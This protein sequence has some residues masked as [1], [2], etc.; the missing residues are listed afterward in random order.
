[1]VETEVIETKTTAHVVSLRK[2]LHVYW[3][4]IIDVEIEFSESR[5]RYMTRHNSHR[6]GVSQM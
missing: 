5:Y 3:C 1:M 6:T 4:A 2:Y